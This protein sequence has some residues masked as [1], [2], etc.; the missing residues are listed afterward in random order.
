M[1]VALLLGLGFG[2][3][4]FGLIVAVAVPL[5]RWSDSTGAFGEKPQAPLRKQ[6]ELIAFICVASGLGTGF[7]LAA[8]DGP[9]WLI[10]PGLAIYCVM[11]AGA[12]IWGFRLRRTARPRHAPAVDDGPPYTGVARFFRCTIPRMALNYGRAFGTAVALPP[13]GI[14]LIIAGKTWFGVGCLVVGAVALIALSR[15]PAKH[16]PKRGRCA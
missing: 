4:M 13:T 3:V 9:H 14:G 11:L 6:L 2:L 7:L 16:R 5:Q 8:G 1:I 10:V 15:A 12:A